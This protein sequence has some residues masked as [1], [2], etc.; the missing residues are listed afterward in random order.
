MRPGIPVAES[1]AGRWVDRLAA[2]LLVGLG[3]FF[4]VLL[5]TIEPDARG[6]GT[7]E[8]LGMEPCSWPQVWGKPCPT[9]GVTTAATLLVHLR[10]VDAV[11]AQPFGAFLAAVGILVAGIAAWS[12]VRGESFVARIALLPY[13]RVLAAAVVLFLASWAYT[14]LTWPAG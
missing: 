9:C 5:A 1:P 6:H 10:P 7:H 14:W 8:Q 4:V 11:V 3:I 12:L 13:G 2:V